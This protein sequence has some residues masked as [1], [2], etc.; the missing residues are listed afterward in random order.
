MDG[1]AFFRLAPPCMEGRG[2]G[3]NHGG[4]E[5]P[6]LAGSLRFSLPFMYNKK[7]AAAAPGRSSER[8]AEEPEPAVSG[9]Q[10]DKKALKTAAAKRRE[11]IFCMAFSLCVI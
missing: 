10:P 4:E 11:T 3:K 5:P 6:F 9:E 7:T 2:K 8:E 1:P